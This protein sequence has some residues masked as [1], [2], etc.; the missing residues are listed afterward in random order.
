M[1]L[2]CLR[3][4]MTPEETLTAVTLNGAAAIGRAEEL[5]S[6]EPGKLADLVIWDS[7]DL[8]Y[9]CYRMGSN[10]AGLVLKK[11]QIVKREK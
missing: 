7:P 10:L 2:A 8:D 4:K 5:G 1:N 11:G 6:L 3:Y 9:L